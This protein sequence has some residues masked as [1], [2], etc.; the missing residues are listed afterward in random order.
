MRVGN[1]SLENL[2]Q[3]TD[4]RDR[5][6]PAVFPAERMMKNQLRAQI[7]T[8]RQGAGIRASTQIAEIP[9]RIVEFMV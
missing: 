1:F 7:G 6:W 9:V 8:L 5:N 3:T 2:G 4:P